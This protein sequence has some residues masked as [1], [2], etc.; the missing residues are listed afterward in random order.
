M[1][2]QKLSLLLYH[3][4]IFLVYNYL[5]SDRQIMLVCVINKTFL[6]YATVFLFMFKS[7]NLKSLYSGPKFEPSISIIWDHMFSDLNLYYTFHIFLLRPSL[8]IFPY[9]IYQ[10]ST[11]FKDCK[12]LES[13]LSSF[14]IKLN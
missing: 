8:V 2:Q 9:H 10:F 14:L 12:L 1:I 3:C 11:Y 6:F 7:I 4:I 13:T 5:P